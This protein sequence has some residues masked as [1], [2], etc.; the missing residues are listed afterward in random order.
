[1]NWYKLQEFVEHK[2]EGVIVLLA[3]PVMMVVLLWEWFIFELTLK[4][5]Q[6][7]ASLFK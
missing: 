5:K 7:V 2:L 3:L 1:M 6:K 4:I